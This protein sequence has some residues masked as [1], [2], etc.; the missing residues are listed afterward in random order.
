[1]GADEVPDLC[2]ERDELALAEE[3]VLQFPAALVDA[4]AG[5]DVAGA[6]DAT[7]TGEWGEDLL[8]EVVVEDGTGACVARGASGRVWGGDGVG[9]MAEELALLVRHGRAVATRGVWVQAET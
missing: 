8:G 3:E 2:L 4:L 7:G 5:I 1:V 9:A 6:S